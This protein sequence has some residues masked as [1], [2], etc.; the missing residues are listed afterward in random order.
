VLSTS[1]FMDLTEGAK[2][3]WVEIEARSLAEQRAYLQQ[4][5]IALTAGQSFAVLQSL[6]GQKSSM[7]STLLRPCG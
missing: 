7:L 1:Y 6:A 4:L 2:F 5:E 3:E